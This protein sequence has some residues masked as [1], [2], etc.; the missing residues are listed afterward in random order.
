MPNTPPVTMNLS[1]A[2]IAVP[3]AAGI[4]LNAPAIPTCTA[5]ILAPLLINDAPATIFKAYAADT[6][7]MPVII[8][9]NTT[10]I[11]VPEAINNP[12]LTIKPPI[13]ELTRI[14]KPSTATCAALPI[15]LRISLIPALP[16]DVANI[17]VLSFKFLNITPR[18][19]T[20]IAAI[21]AAVP[22][23]PTVFNICSN[24]LSAPLSANTALAPYLP[25]ISNASCES[26]TTRF[27][28]VRTVERECTRGS[29]SESDKPAFPTAAASFSGGSTKSE[30]S[31]RKPVPIVEA[32]CPA[33]DKTII[34]ADTS[35]NVTPASDAT[36]PT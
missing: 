5:D 22:D 32:L 20:C 29:K 3:T 1:K 4:A 21:L 18:P 35:S 16:R 9:P 19:S 24:P 15:P 28:F 26:F 31:L 2:A 6:A 13:A 34:E 33:L 27:R 36:G 14:S 17:S 30:K 7:L 25:K 12:A 23:S 8:F 10:T 11:A